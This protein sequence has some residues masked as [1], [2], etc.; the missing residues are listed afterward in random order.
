MR[1]EFTSEERTY[2]DK[3]LT[4]SE[5]KRLHGMLRVIKPDKVPRRIRVLRSQLADSV[6][7]DIFQQLGEHDS[8]KYAEW[9]ERTLRLPI[10]VYTR[11]P[12]AHERIQFLQD[13][14]RKMDDEI[15]GH[16]DAKQEVLR[17]I[18]SWL[19]DGGA[20]FAIG[21]EGDA[22]VGKTTFVKR[23]L[24][25]AL[26]RP[27]CFIGLGGASDASGLLGHSYT[28]EG[29]VPGRLSECVSQSGVMDPVIF[30]DEL[31]KV[32]GTTKGDELYNTLIHLCDPVQNG[33]IRD[34][35]LHGID[36]DFSRA[37]LV[38]SY[39]DATRIN[40]VLLD[41]IKRIRVDA[42]SLTQ[43][44]DICTNHLIPRALSDFKLSDAFAPDV[45]PFLLERSAGDPGMRGIE[46][47]IAHLVASFALV[48][49]YGAID[50]LC[51]DNYGSCKGD[52]LDLAFARLVLRAKPAH[53]KAPPPCL[54]YT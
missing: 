44:I 6:K 2:I 21:L 29:A 8:V 32:S 27:V 18:C 38:F 20:G 17:L 28:Y 36:L 46:K 54:M 51:L 23:A 22:G 39:N 11:P 19:H 43:R 5:A 47:D 26:K 31:D 34:R 16:Q 33:H 3:N 45:V 9:V 14:R 24:A 50:V 41:R 42:P 52:V 13:A 4:R 25:G 15:V 35:Y 37:I 30:F 40:P 7:S 53:A 12:G 1:N 49:M 10:G 48:K